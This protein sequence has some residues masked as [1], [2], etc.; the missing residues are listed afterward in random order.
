MYNNPPLTLTLN[1]FQRFAGGQVIRNAT[2]YTNMRAHVRRGDT[3]SCSHFD[4]TMVN[5]IW[6]S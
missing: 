4:V 6:I 1:A 3:I 2:I 5:T